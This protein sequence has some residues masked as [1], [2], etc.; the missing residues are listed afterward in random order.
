MVDYFER[1][2]V[3]KGKLGSLQAAS[4]WTLEEGVCCGQHI[5]EAGRGSVWRGELNGTVPRSK[6]GGK[7]AG[8]GEPTAGSEQH[9]FQPLPHTFPRHGSP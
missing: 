5:W 9:G 3:P 6:A 1:M 2:F 7:P 4:R 8:A